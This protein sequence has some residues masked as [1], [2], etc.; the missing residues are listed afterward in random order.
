MLVSYF[1]AV[2]IA[3]HAGGEAPLVRRGHRT[4]RDC[5]TVLASGPV[6]LEVLR[7]L[8]GYIPAEIGIVLAVVLSEVST[9]W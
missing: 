9:T 5:D 3:K 4:L 1:A 2:R 7:A 6:Y 8:R